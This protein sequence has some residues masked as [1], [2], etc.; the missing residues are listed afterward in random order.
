M[1]IGLSSHHIPLNVPPRGYGP[2]FPGAGGLD[3]TECLFLKQTVWNVLDISQTDGAKFRART[4][5]MF[6]LPKQSGDCGAATKL[7]MG[8]QC[9]SRVPR[10]H[11]FSQN[12]DKFH[13]VYPIRSRMIQAFSSFKSM[14]GSSPVCKSFYDIH[15]AARSFVHASGLSMRR[16]FLANRDGVFGFRS[17]SVPWTPDVKKSE[18]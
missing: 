6:I 8:Q 9:C 16:I 11:L 13:P 1:R 2:Q 3:R 10:I 4:D 14:C 18:N 12:C 17:G 7:I 5:S 15:R